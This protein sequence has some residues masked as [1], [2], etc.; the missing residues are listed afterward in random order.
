MINIL[1]EIFSPEEVKHLFVQVLF[2]HCIG[3]LIVMLASVANFEGKRFLVLAAEQADSMTLWNV[4]GSIGISVSFISIITKD[5]ICNSIN[6]Y[7]TME[8]TSRIGFIFE[9]SSEKLLN[10]CIDIVSLAFGIISYETLLKHSISNVNIFQYVIIGMSLFV[11]IYILT[12][13]TALRLFSLQ[14][15]TSKSYG[16]FFKLPKLARRVICLIFIVTPIV[17]V[18][19]Y[20]K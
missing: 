6:D 10:A 17:L 14:P 2:W 8:L 20:P 4:I 13:I 7:K 16:L 11:F 1:K 15:P 18:L 19:Y 5:I 12:I 9:Y 3:A